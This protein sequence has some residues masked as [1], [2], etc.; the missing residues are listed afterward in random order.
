[1]SLRQG[2]WLLFAVVMAACI[3][4]RR[5]KEGE[6]LLYTAAVEG[7][8]SIP[9]EEFDAFVRQRPNTRFPLIPSTPYIYPYFWGKRKYERTKAADEVELDSISQRYDRLIAKERDKITAA[10]LK[11]QQAIREI[12]AQQDLDSTRIRSL[13]AD[14]YA[15]YEED[16]LAVMQQLNR[17]RNRRNKKTAKLRTRVEEGNWLMRSVGE[18][19]VVY[20]A[21]LAEQSA[22]QMRKLLRNNGFF[23][24]Q[25]QVRTDSIGKLA[26]LRY[27]I[28]EGRP[29]LLTSVHYDIADSALRRI[30]GQDSAKALLRVAQRYREQDVEQERSRL[31]MLLRNHGYYAF[32]KE[33]VTFK[34][35]TTRNP[36]EAAVTIRIANPAGQTAH[37]AWRVTEVVFES[38]VDAL[39]TR[40]NTLRTQYKGIQY[41]EHFNRYSRK[42]LDTKIA[43]RP[44]S[45]FTQQ[46]TEDTQRA[47]ATLDMFKFVNVKYDTIGDRFRAYIF[48][49]PLE[50]YQVT[51][52]SGLNVTQALPGPFFSA[53]FKQ[54]NFFRACDI[55]ELRGRGGIEGQAAVLD[56][57]RSLFSRQIGLNA[58]WTFPQLVW[59]VP[60]SVKRRL[61]TRMPQTQIL[62]G[63]TLIDRPEYDRRNI[64]ANLSYQWRNRRNAVWNFSLM[65]INAI[66]T[67]FIREDFEQ[68]LEELSAQGN[69]LKFSFQN[70]IISSID[71]SYTSATS[72][73]GKR[74]AR[75]RYFRLYAE[76]GGLTF[77]LLRQLMDENAFFFGLRTFRYYRMQADYR[78]S[79]PLGRQGQLAFRLSG[80][81]ANPYA[82]TGNSGVQVLP[83]EKFFFY[84]GI[85]SNRAWL[86]RRVGPGAF[87]PRQNPDGSFDYSLEQGG[88]II[89]ETNLELRRKLFGFVDGALF[90]DAGNIW[91]V[92]EDPGRPGARW[93]A[94][95]FWQEAAVGIGA[96]LRFDFS[97]LLIRFDVGSKFYDPARLP[98]ARF[99]GAPFSESGQQ[100]LSFGI[101]YPF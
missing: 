35:D 15:K 85:N 40:R 32:T 90:V 50:K 16:S 86:A 69:P 6:K 10:R 21:G 23:R 46:Q 49:S 45:L 89:I 100:I 67:R 17:L 82:G 2:C 26:L 31:T 94:K 42:L 33:Y 34:V 9:T 43:I 7:V 97:F 53:T 54:R 38:G 99:V 19:P 96:G 91:M 48:T 63:Y 30:V 80:G 37:K 36:F 84:G 28:E 66:D 11:I 44:D 55:F 98:G 101:G 22:A 87:S 29:H 5:L 51:F 14:L 76:V 13:E 25:V 24:G 56:A 65:D 18:A 72:N 83:Y 4:V 1:M 73:Y 78:V 27:V 52:E 58:T 74:N 88:E 70:S 95:D 93:E 68:R 71:G 62:L 39:Q 12:H 79:L 3:P 59:L 47:L 61:A 92:D 77:H 60:E 8:K 41:I 64:Q 20:D 75:S 57:S 81:F